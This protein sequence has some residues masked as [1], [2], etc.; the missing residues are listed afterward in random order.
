MVPAAQVPADP[1]AGCT[2][3]TPVPAGTT[4]ITFDS[5]SEPGRYIQHV[6]PA[7]DGRTPVPVVLDLHGYS[8]G[9]DTQA[10]MSEL[11]ALGDA[12]GFV[13]INPEIV[14]TPARWKT[15]LDGN[16]A[17]G[18]DTQWFGQLLDQ[19]EQQLCLD[20]N[21]V[22]V[23]G[24]SDGAIM[25]S[26]LTCALSDRIAAAA[27]VAGISQTQDCQFDRP[28]PVIVFHGTADP[29]ISYEGGLGEAAKNLPA[30]DGG[31]GTLGDVLATSP[32]ASFPSIPDNA[33][34]WAARNGC[35]STPTESP[36]SAD[37]TLVAYPCP[38]GAEVQLYRV[39]DGG[40]AWPGST[41]SAAIASVIG[42][43]TMTIDA[44]T[45]M[46]DFFT[47]PLRPS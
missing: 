13:T 32:D 12:K 36:V 5:G 26:A 7:H 6:P 2:A 15:S 18:G 37:V 40:H 8:E 43:T 30:P 23:T 11:P 34:A 14:R 9:A 21:R 38:E 27:P 10:L 16:A 28:V 4:T 22:F 46:W 17:E 44:N 33:A 31:P 25:T 3:A 39:N 47:H 42:K 20:Q 35:D 45:L 1:S 41:F 24:L 19:A 29:F